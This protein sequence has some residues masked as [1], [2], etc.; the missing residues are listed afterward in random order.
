VVHNRRHRFYVSFWAFTLTIGV[1]H[2]T[3]HITTYELSC[4]TACMHGDHARTTYFKNVIVQRCCSGV[5]PKSAIARA[6]MNVIASVIAVLVCNTQNFL[7]YQNRATGQ[8]AQPYV[9]RY[10][11]QHHRVL[12]SSELGL[13]H[14]AYYSIPLRAQVSTAAEANCA[15]RKSNECRFPGEAKKRLY[16]RKVLNIHMQYSSRVHY[17]LTEISTS[18]T[19]FA[20]SMHTHCFGARCRS[21]ACQ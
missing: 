19:I 9:Q 8:V 13:P 11:I 7:Q 1:T 2:I 21:D 16:E 6:K 5:S 12:F 20:I 18:R 3:I 10:N 4:T 14:L 15:L 17:I